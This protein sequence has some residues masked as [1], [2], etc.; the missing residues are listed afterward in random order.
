MNL[1]P[2]PFRKLHPAVLMVK[3]TQNV[4]RN[5]AAMTLNGAPV[6]SVFAQAEGYCQ[7]NSACNLTANLEQIDSGGYGSAGSQNSTQSHL[8]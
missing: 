8:T 5:N 2:C 7:V 3:S 4:G 1:S 6:R